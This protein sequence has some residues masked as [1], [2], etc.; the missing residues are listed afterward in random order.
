MHMEPA[1]ALIGAEITGADLE[2]LSDAGFEQIERAFTEYQV[3]FF[4]DQPPLAPE[5]QIAFARRFGEPHHHPAAPR[6]EGYPEL[7]VFHAHKDSKFA[8][9]NG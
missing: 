5:A 4:R 2:N 1:T 6:P 3:L 7:F 9:G 8:D